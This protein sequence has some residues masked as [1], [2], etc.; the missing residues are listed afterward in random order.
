MSELVVQRKTKCPDCNEN[1][2]TLEEIP[3]P[4]LRCGKRAYLYD[5]IPLAEALEELN[6]LDRSNNFL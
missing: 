5:D 6:L 4:C 1:G 3:V 2:L